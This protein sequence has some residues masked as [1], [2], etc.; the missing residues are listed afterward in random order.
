ME[1]PVPAHSQP[2]YHAR[3]S[4]ALTRRYAEKLAAY[5]TRHPS[6]G[7]KLPAIPRHPLEHPFPKSATHANACHSTVLAGSRTTRSHHPC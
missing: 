1:V 6:I 2:L 3:Y 7:R 4:L 5:C